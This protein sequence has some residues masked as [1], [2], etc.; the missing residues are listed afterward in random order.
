MIAMSPGEII[1]RWTIL[2]MKSAADPDHFMDD[3]ERYTNEAKRLIAEKD[4]IEM[5]ATIMEMNAKIWVLESDI[6]TGALADSE[7]REIGRRAILIRNHN[8][9]RVKAKASI[10]R[11][12]G[13]IPDKKYN[14]GSAD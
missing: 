6:R 11:L 4:I 8:R 10:D 1:D 7:V 9:V 3:Y 12:F 2:L 5:V 14:H 13:M